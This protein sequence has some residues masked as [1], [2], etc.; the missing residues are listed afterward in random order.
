MRNYPVALISAPDTVNQSSVPLFVGQAAAASF[1]PVF[2]DTTVAGTLTI[3]GSNELPIGAPPAQYVPSAAS[4]C[5]IPG[6]T[7]TVAAGVGPAIVIQTLTFQYIK[8]VF[9]HASGGSGTII[10]NGSFFGV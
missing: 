3:Y 1:T 9:T 6:A 2:S 5:P 7:S 8:A 10:V 4:F